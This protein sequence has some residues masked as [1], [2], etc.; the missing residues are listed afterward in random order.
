[1]WTKGDI[2]ERRKMTWKEIAIGL[3]GLLASISGYLVS[4]LYSQV[5]SVKELK[6]D[7]TEFYQIADR[8]DKKT[9]LIIQLIRDHERN[10]RNDE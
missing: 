4:D 10:R 6:L 8:Q 3:L 1:M 5:K 2:T 7:K 9:D